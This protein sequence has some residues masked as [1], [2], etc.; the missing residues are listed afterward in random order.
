M[1]NYVKGVLKKNIYQIFV[2]VVIIGSN[3]L[4][5]YISLQLFQQSTNFKVAA[6][7]TDVVDIKQNIKILSNLGSK[8]DVINTKLDGIIDR[9]DRQGDTLRTLL[10]K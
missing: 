6:L 1:S 8:V 2:A 10:I 5:I 9:Q 3:L 7:Q 4:S